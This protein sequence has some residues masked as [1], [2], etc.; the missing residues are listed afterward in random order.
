[1]PVVTIEQKI[2]DLGRQVAMLAQSR[3]I[4]ERRAEELLAEDEQLGTAQRIVIN[5]E[6]YY[7]DANGNAYL[8]SI[9]SGGVLVTGSGVTGIAFPVFANNVSVTVGDGVSGFCVPD[10]LNGKNLTRV[11]AR[12]TIKG[13]TGTTSVQ[14]RRN[15]DGTE[16]DMLATALT[17]ADVY[18]SS[19]GV[20]NASNDD[21]ATGDL[22]MVDVDSV[23]SATSP[24]G[25][26]VTLI[27]S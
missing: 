23:H 10:E 22:I 27:F 15:R 9:Y 25:L 5:G 4:V 2:F 21:L 17:L 18:Y 16:V 19:N 1:M 24:L 3:G 6:T 12:V 7:I 11:G 14:V 26:S 13:V 20:I 8:N